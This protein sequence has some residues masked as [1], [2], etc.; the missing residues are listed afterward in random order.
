M[1]KDLHRIKNTVYRKYK[2]K[3]AGV[4]CDIYAKEDKHLFLSPIIN[5]EKVLKVFD[6]NLFVLC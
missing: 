4:E 5:A 2:S 1:S 6:P 3:K